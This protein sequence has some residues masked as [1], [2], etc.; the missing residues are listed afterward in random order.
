MKEVVQAGVK[1]ISKRSEL[2][3][4]IIGLCIKNIESKQCLNPTENLV[5]EMCT[6]SIYSYSPILMSSTFSSFLG[7]SET[8]RHFQVAMKRGKGKTSTTKVC[9]SDRIQF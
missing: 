5:E 9:P 6:I 1:G 4:F 7:T 2:I 8:R 3:P